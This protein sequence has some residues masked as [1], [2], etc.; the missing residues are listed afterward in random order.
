MKIR[1]GLYGH[2]MTRRKT[3]KLERQNPSM[4]ADAHFGEGDALTGGAQC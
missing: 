4:E 2:K 3:S 1:S